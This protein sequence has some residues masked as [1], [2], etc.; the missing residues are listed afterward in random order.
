MTKDRELVE[1]LF[2]KIVQEL[3]ERPGMSRRDIFPKLAAIL[4]LP[5]DVWNKYLSLPSGW[6]S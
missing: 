6:Q 5:D 4:D 3:V 1:R 2:A